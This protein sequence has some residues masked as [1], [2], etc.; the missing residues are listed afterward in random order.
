M[1]KPLAYFITFSGFGTRLHGSEIGSVDR[2]HNQYGNDLIPPKPPLEGY[3]KQI[4]K[5]PTITFVPQHRQLI[6]E[7]IQQVCAYRN[8]CP[9][10][11]HVRTN[12]VHVV[13]S[14]DTKPEKVLHDFQAYAT[15]RLREQYPALKDRKIWTRHGST[16][17]LWTHNAILEAIHY[18]VHEQGEHMEYCYDR[19][20][21]EQ[22]ERM[23]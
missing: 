22:L 21:Y 11:I 1:S 10:A 14:A 12:H 17:Y 15:R 2:H 8:W 23:S 5:S 20:Y 13:V 16:R 7:T 3:E 18:V 6:L 9:L 19:T 4:Q